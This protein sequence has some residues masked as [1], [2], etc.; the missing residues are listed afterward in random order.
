MNQGYWTVERARHVTAYLIGL[1]ESG[2]ALRAAINALHAG[3]PENAYQVTDEPE[4][5]EWLEARHWI[6][7]VVS[8]TPN[9]RTITVTHVES[10]T[11][12]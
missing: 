8:R 10:A 3:V 2:A 11:V 5:W 12:E 7:F 9:R 6:T 4:M 1:R